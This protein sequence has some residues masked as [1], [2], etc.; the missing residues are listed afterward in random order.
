MRRP[1]K[2]CFVP[3][4]RQPITMP[5]KIWIRSRV[6]STTFAC[7]LTES[8]G[9]SVGRFLRS[10]SAS[11]RS[12]TL[13]TAYKDN[14][15]LRRGLTIEQIGTATARPLGGLSAA[16]ALDLGVM[17]GEQH[18]RNLVTLED[19]GPRVMRILQQLLGKR[20][21]FGRFLRTEDT[22]DEPADRIDQHHRRQLAAGEHVITDRAL[23]VGEVGTDPLVDPLVA[24]ADQI[25]IGVRGQFAH[26]LLGEPLP[27]RTQQDDGPAASAR[28]YRFEDGLR[29]EHH[30]GATAVWNVIHLAVPVVRVITQVVKLQ[31]DQPRGQPAARHSRA[32]RTREEFG[33]KRQDLDVHACV[34]SSN[35]TVMRPSDGAIVRTTPR[36]LGIRTSLVPFVTRSTSFAG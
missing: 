15:Q 2:I 5:S 16:P 31:G 26:Q 1:V 13:D 35:S 18:V 10:A 12:I 19:C 32:Q 22:A 9:I 7:T 17:A 8:P 29:L 25:E 30:A 3:L 6:P 23:P 4:T 36:I 33:E 34:S 14:T 28:S 11:S 24:S 20:L 21:V 27:L